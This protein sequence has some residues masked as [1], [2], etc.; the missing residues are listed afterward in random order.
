[1]NHGTIWQH[2]LQLLN[3]GADQSLWPTYYA[4]DEAEDAVEVL[5]ENG[6]PVVAIHSTP[7]VTVTSPGGSS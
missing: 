2:R 3:G 7:W 1:M 5:K 6:F 4:L